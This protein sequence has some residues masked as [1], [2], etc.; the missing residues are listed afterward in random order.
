MKIDIENLGNGNKEQEYLTGDREISL[1]A[2][3][4]Y[5]CYRTSRALNKRED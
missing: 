1:N 5:A 2:E 3:L 4:R